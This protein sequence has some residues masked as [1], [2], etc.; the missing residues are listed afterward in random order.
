[1]TQVRKLLIVGGVA[2]GASS[3]A[4]ARRLSEDAEIV[5]FERG[6]HVSFANCG[7]PYYIGG[8]IA[9]RDRLLV[10]TPEALRK[11]FRLDVR[12]CTEVTAIDTAHREVTA[13]DLATGREYQESYDALI[14]SPGAAPIRPPIPGVEGPRVLTLRSLADMDR[15]QAATK[16]AGLPGAIIVGGGYIGLEMAEALRKRGLPVTIVELMTQVMGPADAEMVTPIHR[17]LRLH[18]VDLRLGAS[19][20][21]L[22]ETPTGITALLSTGETVA[23]G[24]AILAVGVRPDVALVRAAGLRLGERGGIAVDHHMRTSDPHIYAVGDAVEVADLVTHA[25]VLIPLAGPA[26]RQGRIAAD[27]VF[28]RATTY[29]STQGTAICR[30][31]GLAIG[32]TG[33]SEKVLKRAGVAYEKVYVHPA[34]HATYFPGASPIGFKLLFAPGSGRILGAQAVGAEGVDKRIDVVAMALR[35]GLTVFDLE[36]A[37]LCYA[38]PY[39]STRDV[40]NYAGFVAANVL[41]GDV[42]LCHT[43]DVAQPADDQFLL[44]V[45]SPAEAA[46]GTIPG[47]TNIPLDALRGR[48]DELPRN[49]E[50]L[51]FC[52]VGLRGYLACRI[53]EQHGLRCRNLTGGYTTYQMAIGHLPKA[54]APPG[55][56]RDDAGKDSPGE[57]GGAAGGGTPATPTSTPPTPLAKTTITTATASAPGRRS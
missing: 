6:E 19:V 24:F 45:R 35:A 41:R 7:L 43:E 38:P 26:S 42:R 3:A 13:R 5:L 22:D 44:D 33:Q 56:I 51:A 36:E 8:E 10:Q 11:S 30:V 15:I 25:P 9:E 17:E 55:E 27:N 39:G 18:G 14:L 34:N 32:M 48:L 46:A 4:R 37:E 2:G 16:T 57:N 21:R 40:I 1:M 53:L 12:I 47:S 54:P 31:F 49:K 29:K 28:G 50:I 52:Q 23:A 20:T